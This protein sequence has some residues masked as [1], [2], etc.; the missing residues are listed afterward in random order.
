MGD[1]IEDEDALAPAKRLL[2]LLKEQLEEVL[3]PLLRGRK[4]MRLR[5]G[6]M[7]PFSDSG[8]SRTG[9]WGHQERIRQIEAKALRTQHPS[10]SKLKII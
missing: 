5:F 3:R 7:M 8:G 10:R 6:L 4:S 1:F 9:I 2:M